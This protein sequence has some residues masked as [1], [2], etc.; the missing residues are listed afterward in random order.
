MRRLFFYFPPV[1]ASR[2]GVPFRPARRRVFA[3]RVLI[4]KEASTDST[5]ISRMPRL[6]AP[7]AFCL[8]LLVFACGAADAWPQNSAPGGK[9]FKKAGAIVARLR[10]FEQASDAAAFRRAASKFYPGLFAGVS[11]LREGELKTELSTAVWL[12][13]AASRARPTERPDCARELR[14]SYFRLCRDSSDRASLLRAKAALHARRAE[15][16]LRYAEGA[17]DAETLDAVS[18]IRAERD[19]D[20]ALAEEALH[21]LKELTDASAAQPSDTLQPSETL[22][23][24]LDEVDRILASLPRGG[25][26]QLLRDAR[27]AFRDRIYWKSKSQPARALVVSANSLDAPDPLRPANLTADDADR[28]AL[29]NTRAALRFIRLAEEEIRKCK[30]SDR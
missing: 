21:K 13:E 6:R 11:D 18:Q 26:Y 2:E 12:Y 9:E 30:V 28:A 8:F 7:Q 29:A 24:A 4:L 15:A 25:A 20:I 22:P 16:V 10:L 19:T 17:R 14:G 1:T 23:A 5:F 27:D 3:R